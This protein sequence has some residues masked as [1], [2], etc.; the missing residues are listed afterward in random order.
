MNFS[1]IT[2]LL[3]IG[4]VLL[5]IFFA[6]KEKSLFAS[7]NKRISLPLFQHWGI[8]IG[9]LVLLPILNACVVPYFNFPISL[10]LLFTIIA[11]VITWFAHKAWW[12]ANDTQLTFMSPSWKNSKKELRFWYKDLSKAGWVHLLFMT[13]EIVIIAGY[14]F[15]RVPVDTVKRVSVIF[16]AFIPVAFIEP[17]LII[18]RPLRIIIIN[19]AI[20]YSLVIAVAYVKLSL[21]W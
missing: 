9:D 15:S 20:L 18:R 19:A 4:L 17:E 21:N 13:A 1:W 11:F 5:E 16:F 3:T 2:L 14:I 7:Q 8:M 12:P 10:Y 6:W